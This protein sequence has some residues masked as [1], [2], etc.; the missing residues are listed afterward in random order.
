MAK[1]AQKKDN[2]NLIIGIC[3]A[4]LVVVV[5]VVA[6]VF[7]TRGTTK[8]S[9]EYF[10]SDDTKLVLNAGDDEDEFKIHEVYTYSGDDITG[11]T[12]YYEY[13]SEAE[14]KA[15]LDEYNKASEEEKAGIKGVSVNGKYL[16]IEVTEDQYEGRTVSDIKELIELYESFNNGNLNYD[17]EEE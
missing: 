9:D 8:L 12:T 17:Y 15:A 1:K 14:A 10:V 2:K 7:A 4:V 11:M 6:V 3:C 13:K 5:I 16:V